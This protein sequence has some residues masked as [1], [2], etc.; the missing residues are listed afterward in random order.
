MANVDTAKTWFET[1]DKP[2][3]AQFAQLF[4]WL[5]FKDQ[6]IGIEDIDGL[7]TILGLKLNAS[8][9]NAF[10]QGQKIPVEGNTEYVIPEGYILEKVVL[11]PGSDCS[12]YATVGDEEIVPEDTETVVTPAQG[13]LWVVNIL[14]LNEKTLSIFGLPASSFVIYFKRKIA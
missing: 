10:E 7:A 3:Q 6:P 5:R 1:K 13:A 14:A 9:F 8:V 2:T 12:P 4:E 11:I